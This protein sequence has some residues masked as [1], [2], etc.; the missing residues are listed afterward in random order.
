MFCDF[1]GFGIFWP[2]KT[3]KKLILAFSSQLTKFYYSKVP[4]IILFL[5][6]PIYGGCSVILNY[7]RYVVGD[8]QGFH[9]EDYRPNLGKIDKF[10]N[11]QGISFRFTHQK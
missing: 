1:G 3:R 11:F 7:S 6:I 9:E 4:N 5:I 2:K 8:F 10:F